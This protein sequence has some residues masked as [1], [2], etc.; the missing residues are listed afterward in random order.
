MLET[1]CFTRTCC[2]YPGC[3][4][5]LSFFQFPDF[6]SKFT[7][8]N[9]K[10]VVG[11]GKSKEVTSESGLMRSADHKMIWVSQGPLQVPSAIGTNN[12]VSAGADF[13]FFR[14]QGNLSCRRP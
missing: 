12:T 14:N 6:D 13:M 10:S 3:K 5:P 4:N 8:R 9:G 1:F 7:A 2:H 11:R